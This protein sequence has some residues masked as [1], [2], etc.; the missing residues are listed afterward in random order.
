[1]SVVVPSLS[2]AF[3]AALSALRIEVSSAEGP[4][5]SDE[6]GGGALA[7]RRGREVWRAAVARLAGTWL[8]RAAGRAAGT[9]RVRAMVERKDMS[10]CSVGDMKECIDEKKRWQSSEIWTT[11]H[12]LIIHSST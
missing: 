10:L 12:R 1:M 3:I 9:S 8:D 7:L 6:L 4:D 5:G 2:R 11:A